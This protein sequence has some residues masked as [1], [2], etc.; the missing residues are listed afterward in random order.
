MDPMPDAHATFVTVSFGPLILLAFVIAFFALAWR[1]RRWASAPARG[2]QPRHLVTRIVCGTLGAA[3]LVAVAVGTWTAARQNYAEPAAGGVVIRVPTQEPPALRAPKP[4]YREEADDARFLF[5]LVVGEPA[6]DGFT[7]VHVEEFDVRWPRDKDR[8]FQRSFETGPYRCLLRLRVPMVFVAQNTA[9][10]ASRLQP[11]GTVGFSYVTGR[12]SGSSSSGF[13]ELEAGHLNVLQPL[14]SGPNPLSITAGG[15][16]PDNLHAVYFMTRV[17]PD[18]PLKVVPFAEFA[19]RR[20]ADLAKIRRES[21]NRTLRH[22]PAKNASL[23]A[24][25]LALAGHIGVSS[26]LLLAAA[27]LLTQLFARRSLA[28][29]GV[30]AGVVLYVAAL[31]RMALGVHLS[32][33]ADPAASLPSRLVA[34]R[35]APGTFFHRE[36]ALRELLTV[37]RNASAPEA[38]RTT[39]SSIAAEWGDRVP[40]E[41]VR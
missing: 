2:P 32:R 20:P 7:P 12:G 39:A 24:C 15:A 37:S 34:C 38:L 31:D 19:G 13:Y 33:L 30:L 35:L 11:H 8:Q 16:G 14:D 41:R 36:T 27:V 5:H 21:A 6:P 22:G 23:P 4:G 17:A 18:D 28:F 10:E 1:T 9:Q 26:L 40:L 3:I 29:A 25:G